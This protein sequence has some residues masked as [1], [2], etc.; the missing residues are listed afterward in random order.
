MNFWPEQMDNEIKITTSEDPLPSVKS[1]RFLGVTIDNKLTWTTHTDNLIRKLS[2]NKILLSKAKYL[3]NPEAKRLIYFAH[4]H[5]HLTYA[6]TVWSTNTSKKQKTTIEK[7]QKYCLRSIA[8]KKHN[9]HTDPLFKLLKI[10]KFDDIIRMEQGKLAYKIKT[11]L[12]Q[13]QFW[14]FLTH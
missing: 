5:S 10:L 7:I 13:H 2:A 12:C 3:M 6:N 9:S 4:I 11:N 8:N 1:T 14:N